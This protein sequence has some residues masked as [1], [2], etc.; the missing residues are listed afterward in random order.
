MKVK[1]MDDT[2]Q[3][4]PWRVF[5][6]DPK[7]VHQYIKSL[8]DYCTTLLQKIDELESPAPDGDDM[9]VTASNGDDM[10]AAPLPIKVDEP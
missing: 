3:V 5:G 6:Y 9:D 1:R 4:F 10:D 7:A 2:I 8:M